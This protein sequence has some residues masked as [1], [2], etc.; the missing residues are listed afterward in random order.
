MLGS[1]Y[2]RANACCNA[3]PWLEYFHVH[4]YFFVL[5]DFLSLERRAN[6]TH[7]V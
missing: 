3:N 2:K 6:Y 1:M 5:L 7:Q 4:H